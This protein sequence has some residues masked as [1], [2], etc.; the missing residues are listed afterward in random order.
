[1]LLSGTSWLMGRGVM[2]HLHHQ[3]DL[4]SPGRHTPR[5][6]CEGVQRGS[7]RRRPTLKV[8]LGWGLGLN[9]R[10]WGEESQPSVSTHLSLLCASGCNVTAALT[11]A[12]PATATLATSLSTPR[13]MDGR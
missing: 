8:T 11:P 3:L 7:L 13:R 2:A 9:K 12:A 5:H 1:M 4:G 6:V 10:G